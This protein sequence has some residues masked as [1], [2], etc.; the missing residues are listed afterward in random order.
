[1]ANKNSMISGPVVVSFCL[2]FERCGDRVFLS[3]P[4]YFVMIGI[5]CRRVESLQYTDANVCHINDYTA[6]CGEL[7]N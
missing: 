1:M 2:C 5:L 6:I 4:E 7:A 3:A